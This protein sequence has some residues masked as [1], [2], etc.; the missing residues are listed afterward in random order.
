[1]PTKEPPFDMDDYEYNECLNCGSIWSLGTEEYDFQQCDACGWTPG[2]P[3]K[4]DLID[5]EDLID[6]D[7][8]L[9]GF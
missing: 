1:M 9:S 6:P 3:T 8:Y 4:E 5:E 2:E 7:H